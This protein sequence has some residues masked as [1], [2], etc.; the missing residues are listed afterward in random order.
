[1]YTNWKTINK[2][3]KN[4]L[5]ATSYIWLVIVPIVAKLFSL[6][7]DTLDFSSVVPG[8]ILSLTLPFSWKLFYISAVFVVLGNLVYNFCCPE[9]IKDY[10]D[11]SDFK[12]AGLSSQYLQSYAK[13]IQHKVDKS[14]ENVLENSG[15]AQRDGYMKDL[16]WKISDQENTTGKFSRVIC[17][18]LYSIGLLLLLP[19]IFNNIYYVV[20]QL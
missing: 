5:L 4:K 1:M 19:T 14:I 3:G 18:T 20:S 16:F 7:E 11:Y 17:F 6:A 15:H 12:E 13:R 8:L 9:I 10:P 2:L